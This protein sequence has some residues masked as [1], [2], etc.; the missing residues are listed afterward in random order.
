[1]D[2]TT[3][4]PMEVTTMDITRNEVSLAAAKTQTTKGIAAGVI[5]WDLSAAAFKL[6]I[7]DLIKFI[8]TEEAHKA[9]CSVI[10]R[11]CL[12]LAKK[13]EIEKAIKEN[14]LEVIRM[15]LTELEVKRQSLDDLEAE[16]DKIA[17]AIEALDGLFA[18]NPAEAAVKIRTLIVESKRINAA[19][20]A[21]KLV[22]EQRLATRRANAAIATD[23]SGDD[24]ED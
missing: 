24:A 3:T 9:L 18:T 5:Y 14:N 2:N 23:S 17:K 16:Q 7:T 1:M 12:T 15:A 19:I 10:R 11:A 13:D 22:Q 21:I 4:L 20:A 6:S 8:G